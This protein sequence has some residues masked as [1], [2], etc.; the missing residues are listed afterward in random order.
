MADTKQTK[1][2]AAANGIIGIAQQLAILRSNINAFVV[3]YNSEGYSTVWNNL[4]TAALNT[5]GSLGTADSTPNVS[6]P[7]DTRVAANTNLAK[8]VSATQLINAV[9]MIEQ[10]QNFFTNLAVTQ[11]NYNITVDDLAN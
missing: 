9:A 5:D 3:P 7:I 2:I 11:N 1:A 8:A 10:L 4:A 6:H